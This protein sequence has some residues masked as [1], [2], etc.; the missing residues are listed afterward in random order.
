MK[1]FVTSKNPVKISAT[2]QGFKKVYPKKLIQI[3]SEKVDSGVSNQPSSDEE[4]LKGALQRTENALREYPN[5]DFYVGIEGG[6][7]EK[8]NHTFSFAWVVIRSKKMIGKARSISFLIPNQAVKLIYQ[9]KEL[10]EAMDM[11]FG[12]TNIKHQEGAIGI[13]THGLIDR[14]DLYTPVIIS[15]LIP[16]EN[17][18]LFKENN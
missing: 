18:E 3:E 12:K 16:F 9:G 4:T 15:A 2:R 17:L 11:I 6:I 7:E 8:N 13:L 5:H 1:I 10:G 14:T